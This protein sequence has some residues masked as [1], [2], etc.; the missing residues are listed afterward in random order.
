MNENSE[1][2]LDETYYVISGYWPSDQH[3]L[4]CIQCVSFK[5]E[6]TGELNVS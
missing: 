6:E 2:L 5:N 3:V 1:T 4:F